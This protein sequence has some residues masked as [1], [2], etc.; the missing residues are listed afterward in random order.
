MTPKLFKAEYNIKAEEFKKF[1]PVNVNFSFRSIAP[2]ISLCERK[3]LIPLLGEDF[4]I[5]SQTI[6]T[7]QREKNHI[8]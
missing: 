6:T 5:N 1:L 4:L 2:A 7:H 8:V 3:Y